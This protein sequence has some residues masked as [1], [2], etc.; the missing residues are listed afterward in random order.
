[1]DPRTGRIDRH[2]SITIDAG[3]VEAV[4]PPAPGAASDDLTGAYVVPGYNDM[5]VHLVNDPDA[6]RY[7]SLMLAHGV[8]GM[9]QMSGSAALLARRRAGTLDLGPHAPELLAMPGEVLSPFIA[10]SASRLSAEI[11]TQAASG[12]D[13]IKVGLLSPELLDVALS[14]AGAAGLPIGGHLPSG[15]DVAHAVAAGFRFVEHLGPGDPLWIASSVEQAALGAEA[16]AQQVLR[17]PP[18]PA[19][20]ARFTLK[21]IERRLINPAAYVRDRTVLR[22]DR[23]IRTHDPARERTLAARLAAANCW[24]V[25]TLVRLRTQEVRDAAT[26]AR[27]ADFLPR[28]LLRDWKRACAAFDRRAERVRTAHRDAY[29]AQL[30]MTAALDEADVPMMTGTDTIVP[31]PPGIALHEEFDELARAGVPAL[32]ILQMT[33]SRPADFLDL[34][35]RGAVAPGSPADLVLLE[36][37]PTAD[38]RNLHRIRAVVRRGRLYRRAD[39]DALT[40]SARTSAT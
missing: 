26:D 37:D 25:P 16:R 24:Q 28:R 7:F 12:A 10:R 29:A 22:L 14:A 2:R 11:S 33:T 36:G 30:R 4:D 5:H 6:S 9:R 40:S 1:M 32:R 27:Y 8:T 18:I 38:S 20:L 17:L 23:A 35:A 3:R 39:L 21:R 15:I 13:F 19:L 31:V 34:P